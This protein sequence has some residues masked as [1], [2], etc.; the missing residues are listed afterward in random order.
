M[1][2]IASDLTMGMGQTF[3]LQLINHSQILHLYIQTWLLLEGNVSDAQNK[4]CMKQRYE[5]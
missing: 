5:V 4:I 1:S 2:I 3:H